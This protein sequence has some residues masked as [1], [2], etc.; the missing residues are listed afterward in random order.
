[1]FFVLLGSELEVE[2]QG[3]GGGG[4]KRERSGQ[5]KELPQDAVPPLCA[6]PGCP[7]PEPRASKKRF[8]QYEGCMA[9]RYCSETKNSMESKRER[10]RERENEKEKERERERKKVRERKRERKRE[11]KYA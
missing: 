5:P 10:K 2:S 9:D 11:N 8:H 3:G 1:M 7:D 6:N 4:S